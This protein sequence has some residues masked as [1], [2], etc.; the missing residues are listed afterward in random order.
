M[1]NVDTS[2][3]TSILGYGVWSGVALSN[4][5]LQITK[6]VIPNLR[7]EVEMWELWEVKVKIIFLT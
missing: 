1:T 2:N 7:I 4:K 6:I 3:F 5:Q